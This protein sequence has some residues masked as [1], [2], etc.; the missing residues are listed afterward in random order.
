MKAVVYDAPRSFSYRET[1]DPEPAADEALVRIQFGRFVGEALHRNHFAKLELGPLSQILRGVQDKV[2]VN[3]FRLSLAMSSR[4]R[5][6]RSARMCRDFTRASGLLPIATLSAEPAF[7]ACAA[8]FSFV[9]T[10]EP[11][12]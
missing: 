2:R 5:S 7:I 4:V 11:T 1:A 8:I 12:G 6:S 9:K 3:G 10:W